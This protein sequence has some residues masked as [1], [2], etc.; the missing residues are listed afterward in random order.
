MGLSPVIFLV[1][2]GVFAFLATL[3]LFFNVYHLAK[4]GLHGTGTKLI[5]AGYIFGF[6]A[7]LIG[8]FWLMGDY[9]WSRP[10]PITENALFNDAL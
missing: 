4:F 8:S 3:W 9:D 1:I 2:Y 10:I 5:I 7:L 6:L